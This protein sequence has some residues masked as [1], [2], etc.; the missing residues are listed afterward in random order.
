MVWPLP[1]V[2]FESVT[3]KLLKSSPFPVTSTCQSAYSCFAAARLI[4]EEPE[5]RS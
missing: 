1:S 2:K 4:E 5:M 3:S